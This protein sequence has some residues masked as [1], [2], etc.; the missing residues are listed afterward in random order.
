[1]FLHLL[2]YYSYFIHPLIFHV[3]LFHIK[4]L[5][6]L[7]LFLYYLLLLLHPF[8]IYHF[9][10][11]YSMSIIPSTPV[12][13]S[14][15]HSTSLLI[16]SSD[17]IFYPSTF[18]LP[19]LS[20]CPPPSIDHLSRNLFSS[21]NPPRSSSFPAIAIATLPSHPSLIEKYLSI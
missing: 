7:I 6:R 2:I 12:I 20:F 4:S 21:Y 8:C 19:L 5:S 3:I 17:F 9:Y 18:P 10:S 1:M 11:I 13:S 16:S 14:T 15:L